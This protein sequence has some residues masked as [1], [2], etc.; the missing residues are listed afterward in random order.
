MLRFPAVILITVPALKA[1]GSGRFGFGIRPVAGAIS[2][3]WVVVVAK[4]IYC[5]LS[6]LWVISGCDGPG[7]YCG[8]GG[9]GA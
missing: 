8:G 5:G 1:A 6:S 2:S 3:A 9:A 4:L 7:S